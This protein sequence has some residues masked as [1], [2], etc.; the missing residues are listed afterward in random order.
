MLTILSFTSSV[1]LPHTIKD[2]RKLEKVQ[3]IIYRITTTKC[4]GFLNMHYVDRLKF[5]LR[6]LESVQLYSF[7]RYIYNSGLKSTKSLSFLLTNKHIGMNEQKFQPHLFN[8][9]ADKT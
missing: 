3:R 2:F 4:T 6:I 5:N 7:K 1:W 9:K 8:K